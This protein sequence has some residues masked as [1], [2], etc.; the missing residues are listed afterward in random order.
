M[1]DVLRRL[2]HEAVIG[3][4]LQDQWSSLVKHAGGRPAL[5]NYEFYR[6]AL[7]YQKGNGRFHHNLFHIGKVDETLNAYRHLSRNWT[8]LKFAGDGHDVIYV[9][10][11]E[12]N[13][14][15]SAAYMRVVMTRLG[16]PPPII[17]E[18][19]RIINI[20]K[21]H[22]TSEDDI[23]GKLMIDADF[24]ILGAPVT[25][26]T[27]YAQ[28]IW[29]EYVGTGKYTPKEFKVGRV[30]LLS[31]WL[32][33]DRLFLVDEVREELEQNARLNMEREITLLSA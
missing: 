4:K 7:E 9:P 15:D 16:M 5:V 2:P 3:A 22:K 32:R 27:A 19:E 23:D 12:T 8:A 28:N 24:T 10:G 31:Q 29:Q 30:M 18:S 25:E 6:M 1:S 17:T 11:S 14:L 33:Q 26:Y 21:D 20:T 13:E